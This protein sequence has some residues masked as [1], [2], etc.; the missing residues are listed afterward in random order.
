MRILLLTHDLAYGGAARQLALLAAGLPRD[1]FAVRVFTTRPDA[2]WSL[3][4]REAGVPVES[5][6]RRRLFD[7]RGL[8]AL[9]TALRQFAPDV[10]HVF[11]DRKSVVEGKG[12][13]H[14]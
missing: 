7:V 13:A 4:L 5:G 10:I 14:G 3:A 8:L 9:R 12:V 6:G 1:R 2:P 11:G